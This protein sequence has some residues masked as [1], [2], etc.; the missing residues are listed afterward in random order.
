MDQEFAE[1]EKV[2]L[3]RSFRRLQLEASSGRQ[4]A[5]NCVL[6]YIRAYTFITLE[7]QFLTFTQ[8]AIKSW[9][10]SEQNDLQIFFLLIASMQRIVYGF[11]IKMFKTWV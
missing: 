7:F 6:Q 5:K 4:N 9:F 8:W 10:N 1:A 11:K 3:S 2:Y